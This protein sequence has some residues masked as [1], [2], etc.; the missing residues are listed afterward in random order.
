MIKRMYVIGLIL[1][2]TPGPARADEKYQLRPRFTAGQQWSEQRINT[3]EMATTVKVGQ[4]VMEQSREK[5][6]QTLEYEWEVLDIARER[7]AAARVKFGRQC[8]GE[9]ESNGEKQSVKFPAAGKTVEVRRTKDNGMKIKPADA[10]VPEVRDFLEDLF[11]PD[12][13]TFPKEPLAIGES[14]SWAKQ[15]V[16]ETFG[17]GDD[18]GGSVTCTLKSV[19]LREGRKTVELAIRVR[20]KVENAQESNGQRIATLTESNLEGHGLMDVAAGRLVELQLAGNVVV[21]G[22]VSAPDAN[23]NMTPQADLDGAGRM[24]LE[25]KARILGEK[26]ADE[27]SPAA[28]PDDADFT[29]EYANSEMQLTLKQEAD[30][31]RGTI[32]LGGRELPVKGKRDG[33]VL[34][35]AFQS[36]EHWFD[37]TAVLK[38]ATLSLTTGGKTHELKKKGTPKNPLGGSSSEEKPAKQEP[39]NP[40]GRKTDKD[41]SKDQKASADP[42]PKSDKGG[43]ASV[44]TNYTVYRCLDVQGFRDS[45]GRPLE[46]FR[47]LLPEGWQF[48]GGLEWKINHKNVTALSRV[49]LVNPVELTFKVSSPGERVVI[50]AYP[51]VHF[52]DLRGSPAYE[53]GAFPTGSDYAG[54]TV[55]PTMDPVSYIKEFV[56]PRQRGGLRNARLVETKDLPSVVRRY[57]REMAIVNGA[58]QGIAA[59]SIAHQAAVVVVDHDQNGLAAREA[60]LVVLAYLQTPGITMWSSRL[61][62]SMRSP[63]EE[64]D[65][66]QPV[67]ATMLNSVEFNMRW[68]GELLRV[69]K[70]AEGV[71]IDVDRFCRQVDSEITANRAETNA[72]I[73]RDMYPRLA[74]Y[75]DHVGVDGKRYFLETDQQHQMNEK[76]QIRSA[77]TLPDEEGWTRMPE[78]TGK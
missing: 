47:M 22:I 51:E 39:P 53:M 25:A 30:G 56:I 76:G 78:Y 17:L 21:S 13:G 7:P 4:Q 20:L 38:G 54:F 43:P 35:G 45:A 72:Q 64:V 27:P 67:V 29:G 41:S 68:V 9:A 65:R 10:D 73:H 40:L 50:Q 16:A 28:Q 1:L 42:K 2:C 8:G 46:V 5:N 36:E 61:N 3:Y 74:P 15:A 69:Q 14:W 12:L 11:E 52:A 58:L 49:D 55:C 57:D 18:D 75:C 31:Y 23:G 71:I 66:W 6:R 63:R 70:Q 34:K 19:S 59:G 32:T 26:K 48:S 33:A 62:L 44:A 77:V 37:F 60:F 24:T